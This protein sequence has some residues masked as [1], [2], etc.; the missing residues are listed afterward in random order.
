MTVKKHLI[1]TE[2]ELEQLRNSEYVANGPA[3]LVQTFHPSL[4][5]SAVRS[6]L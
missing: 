5:D 6:M 3:P 2:T 1:E 4:V